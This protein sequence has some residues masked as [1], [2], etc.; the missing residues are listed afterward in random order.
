MV[1]KLAVAIFI[2][3]TFTDAAKRRMIASNSSIECVTINKGG[4]D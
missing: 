2:S 1:C 4:I 3:V